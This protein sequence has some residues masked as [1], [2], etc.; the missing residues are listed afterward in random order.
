LSQTLY[1]RHFGCKIEVE[2]MWDDHGVQVVEVRRGP[3]MEGF[4]LA[5]NS[6][7]PQEFLY[8]RLYPQPEGLATREDLT[9]VIGN[10]SMLEEAIIRLENQNIGDMDKV[11]AARRRIMESAGVKSMK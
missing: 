7:M 11:L 9:K 8:W 2:R 3:M 1:S 6:E 5:V 10:K 4:F